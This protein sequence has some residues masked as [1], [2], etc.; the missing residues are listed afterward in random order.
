MILYSFRVH[1]NKNQF[2]M[3]EILLLKG[4]IFEKVTFQSENFRHANMNSL[5]P[6][7]L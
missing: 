7:V 6:Y 2:S 5:F 1:T 3:A 4:L